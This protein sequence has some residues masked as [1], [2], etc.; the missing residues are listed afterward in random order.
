M[1]FGIAKL[2]QQE[3]GL[4]QTGMTLGTASY[5]APEQIQGQPVSHSTDIFSFGV[6]AYELLTLQRPFQG[7]IISNVLFQILKDEPRPITE[8]WQPAPADICAVINRCLSKNQ[9]DRYADGNGLRLAL[10]QVQAY[11]HAQPST[12]TEPIAIPPP[13]PPQPPPQTAAVARDRPSTVLTDLAEQP[14]RTLDSIE[15]SS[16]Q[17]DLEQRP[18]VP[19]QAPAQNPMLVKKKSKTL[20]YGA[21]ILA[22]IAALGIGLWLG[23][24]QTTP[25]ETTPVEEIPPAQAATADDAQTASTNPPTEDIPPPVAAPPP[26]AAAPPPPPPAKGILAIPAAGWT[27][28]MTVQLGSEKTYPLVRSWEFNLS[29]GTHRATFRISENGYEAEATVSLQVRA[30]GRTAVEIPIPR[31]GAVSVRARPGRPQGAIFLTGPNGRIDLGQSPVSSW[32]LAP[33]SYQ[34]EISAGGEP[35][36]TGQ[37]VVLSGQEKVLTFDLDGTTLRETAKDLE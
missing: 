15:L 20:Q 18:T 9:Q 27:E 16:T 37:V 11:G 31:P 29:P 19:M 8:L 3:S 32:L 35:K 10:E 25:P 34:V 1:D 5:L 23:R 17:I 26:E 24:P 30:D 7:E 33:G 21:V 2:A 14:T 6:L 13:P 22:C 28:A 4:T 12:P 36:L